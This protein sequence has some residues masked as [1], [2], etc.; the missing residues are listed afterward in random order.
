MNFRHGR[1]LFPGS[2]MACAVPRSALSLS[3]EC[4]HTVVTHSQLSAP[5]SSV[6][7]MRAA[8]LRGS[9]LSGVLEQP[10]DR[11]LHGVRLL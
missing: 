10:G 11:A 5:A 9:R 7:R 6:S 1:N 3:C 8:V 4:C 2:E